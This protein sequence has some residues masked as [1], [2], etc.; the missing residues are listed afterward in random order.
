MGLRTKKHLPDS[1][2]T[3]HKELFCRQHLNFLT[4]NDIAAQ[5]N[6]RNLTRDHHRGASTGDDKG[7]CFRFSM[8]STKIGVHSVSNQ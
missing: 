1:I 8:A 4:V 6:N 2:L 3:L 5:G 7:C